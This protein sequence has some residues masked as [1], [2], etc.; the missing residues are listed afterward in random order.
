MAHATFDFG[1]N[2]FSVR[3]LDEKVDDWVD[4]WIFVGCHE[5]TA[6]LFICVL[7]IDVESLFTLFIN[8]EF[9]HVFRGKAVHLTE[10]FHILLQSLGTFGLIWSEFL[11]LTNLLF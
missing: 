3:V 4:G 2:C 10:L 6:K 5:I 8:C 7:H 1:D 9:Q 11:Q